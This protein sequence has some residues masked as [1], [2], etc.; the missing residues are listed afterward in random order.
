M[1]S[2][3]Y[4]LWEY[5]FRKEEFRILLVG[6]DNA[7][8]TNILEKLKTHFSASP[9]LEADKILPTVGLNVARLEA[10]PFSPCRQDHAL[11]QAWLSAGAA[12]HPQQAW[13]SCVISL[14]GCMRVV[15]V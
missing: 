11:Q 14:R 2:L 12:E 6:L 13:S 4:G 7:G 8:K 3:A 5:I 15:L 9:G 10:F 1:F